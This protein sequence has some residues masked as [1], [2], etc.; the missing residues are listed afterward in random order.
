VSIE[1]DLAKLKEPFASA[2]IDW[3][4][5][6]AWKSGSSISGRAL[7]YVTN[8]AIMDRLDDACGPQNWKN[9]FRSGPNGGTVCGISI[10]I[11]E[12]WVT[13]WDGADNTDIEKVK[14]GLSGAMK[15]AA[16]QWGI[17]RYLYDLAADWITVDA[18]GRY[19]GQ[20]KDKT[21]GKPEDFRWNP[22]GLPAWALPAAKKEEKKP[23]AKAPLSG[24]GSNG[25]GAP[26]LKGNGAPGSEVDAHAARLAQIAH[27]PT[28]AALQKKRAEFSAAVEAGGDYTAEDVQ[29]YENAFDKRGRELQPKREPA[30]S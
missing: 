11:G 8:R 19:A 26:P 14:G 25:N 9:E 23:P 6:R 21:G 18:K 24:E 12:E 15:R 17:G 30:H 7:A 27:V 2:D 5:Q 1:I 10:R 29:R 13:K 4:L 20:I 22:P 28:L 16:V 3:R